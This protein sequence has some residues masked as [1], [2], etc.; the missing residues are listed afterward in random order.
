MATYQWLKQGESVLRLDDMKVIYDI[1]GSID[2]QLVR[3]HVASGGTILPADTSVAAKFPA[4][5]IDNLPKVI[6]AAVLA[7]AAMSNKTPAQAKAAF[8]AAWNS[9]P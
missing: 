6:K 5:D 4:A 3:E 7:A 8:I 9:L 1:P 2:Y